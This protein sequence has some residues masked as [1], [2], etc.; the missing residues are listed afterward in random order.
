MITKLQSI[1][2]ERL[3]K[4]EQSEGGGGGAWSLWEGETKDF[5]ANWVQVGMGEKWNQVEGK[6]G[7]V[8]G[9]MARIGR[10]CQ[11]VVCKPNTV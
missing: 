10:V 1:D 7:W 4:E 2:P 6:M 11:G 9:E 5:R 8:E 3:G